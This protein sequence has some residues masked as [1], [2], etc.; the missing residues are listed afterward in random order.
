MF[1]RIGGAPV[2][3][4]P[5]SASRTLTP[6]A[7]ALLGAAGLAS[8]IAVWAADLMTVAYSLNKVCVPQLSSPAFSKA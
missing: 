3:R 4:T 6:K 1:Q 5:R 2:S 8:V 7:E